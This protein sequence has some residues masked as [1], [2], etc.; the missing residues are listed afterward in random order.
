MVAAERE[1]GGM[2][3]D[4]FPDIFISIYITGQNTT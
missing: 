4:K 3:G 1:S 2:G